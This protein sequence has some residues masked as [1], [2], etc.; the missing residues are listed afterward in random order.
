MKIKRNNE[1]CFIRV[2]S[3][4]LTVISHQLTV[5]D[6]SGLSGRDKPLPLQ[7]YH[8]SFG[9][10]DRKPLMADLRS[11]LSPFQGRL[12]I[13]RMLQHTDKVPATTP[14]SRTGRHLISIY[15]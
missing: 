4:Q 5:A 13:N 15:L 1:F 7:P 8:R 2:N 10:V 6:A 12:F 14:K 9:F 11:C 3:Q